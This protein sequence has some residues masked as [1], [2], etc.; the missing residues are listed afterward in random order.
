[1]L[2]GRVVEPGHVELLGS[3]ATLVLNICQSSV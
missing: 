3:E 2:L 1:M